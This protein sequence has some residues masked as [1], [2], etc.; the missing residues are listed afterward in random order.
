MA[1]FIPDS[2]TLRWVVIAPSRMSRPIE[3]NVAK[4]C[5]FCQGNEGLTPP[6]VYRV[7]DG[8]ANKPGWKVR[9]IPNK[10]PITDI[11]EVII[12]SPAEDDINDMDQG[13]LLTL[14]QTYRQRWNTHQTHGRV[15]IFCNRGQQ[16]GASILH[17]HSQLVVIPHQIN[18]DVLHREPLNNLVEENTFFHVWCPDFSQWPYEVW[19]APKK[20]GMT[21]GQLSD[22]ELIDLGKLLQKMLALLKKKFGDLP[23]NFYIHPG[24]D[25]Y[26]R[27]IP[28]L[29]D[30]AGFELGT[31]L[32]VNIIDPQQAAKE[33]KQ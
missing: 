23:Y 6:E 9:V 2:Q 5:I 16:A 29:I 4:V 7:G 33:L 20:S 12:H 13:S 11:H 31:G 1:R 32:S 17:P 21:F 10:Y 22:E 25:W 26:L 8:E 27:I 15:L 3:T 30:R 18:L 28:R 19:I 24:Q 14:L